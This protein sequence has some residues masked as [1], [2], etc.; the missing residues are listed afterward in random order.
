MVTRS[1]K[2][3]RA[4]FVHKPNGQIHQRVQAVGPEHFGIVSVDCA[5]MRSKFLL[6]D[7][8]GN[9]LIPPTVLA[10]HQADLQA[11]VSQIRQAQ[12]RHQLH[13]LIVAIERTGT[14]HRPVQDAF[15]SAGWETRLV[16]PFAS[17]QFR[18]P[19]DPAN[20]TDDTD[21][22]GIFRATVNGFGLV[23]PVWPEEYQQL[24]LL[25]RHRR[26]LVRKQAK[27]RCQIRGQ[28]HSL[29]PGLA[30]CFDDLFDYPVVLAIVARTGSAQAVR[31]LGLSGLRHIVDQCQLRC[32]L[33]SLS[34]ILA[35]AQAAL[36]PAPSVD[37]RRQ[38]LANLEEDRQAKNQQIL[39]LERQL[40]HLLVRTP[41]ALLLVIPGLNVVS[42]AELAGELGPITGYA[43]ANRI[44]G[45]AGLRPSRY[46][47]DTVDRANGPLK[48]C[49]NRRLRYALLQ[50]A[51]NLVNCNHYFN[52][53]AQALQQRGKDPHWIRVKIAKTFSRLAFAMVTSGNVF[54]HPCCQERHYLLD[55]LLE[56]HRRRDTPM[57]LVL[58]DLDAATGQLPRSCYA[59]EAK[60]LH[61]RLQQWQKRKRGPQP[62]GEILPIVLARLGIQLLPSVE[63]DPS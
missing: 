49:S 15:R 54:R 11:A 28:L 2:S 51:D 27:L 52:I 32:Q 17:C 12:Q 23:D 25:A 7:F 37:L 10:H 39:R 48:R 22:A 47:S 3:S 29:M 24:Q 40:A 60:P 18:Q 33:S 50:V 20:K 31:D 1:K 53:Q 59:E 4:Y 13:D 41:Y 55:K 43:N 62:L 19:A 16:H 45:R 34:K 5:K 42:V 14:Y 21:L 46:Q 38:I 8:F 30:D 61:Q 36:A 57:S 56:F 35:W 6:C 9:I 26:D 44:T 63:Q 58:Q